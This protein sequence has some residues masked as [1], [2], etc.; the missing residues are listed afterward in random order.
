MT[1]LGWLG[2]KISTQ[3]KKKK[4]AGCCKKGKVLHAPRLHHEPTYNLLKYVRR[5]ISIV[6]RNAQLGKKLPWHHA[7][8]VT[9]KNKNSLPTRAVCS[10]PHYARLPNYSPGPSV[11]CR[12]IWSFTVCIWWATHEKGPIA[13]C[14]QCRPWSACA[15]AQA[16]LGHRCPLT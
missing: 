12:V 9:G 1:P 14:G 11:M 13:I 2:R 3:K 10:W 6:M 4:I 5:D 8:A 16:D 7:P 15:F